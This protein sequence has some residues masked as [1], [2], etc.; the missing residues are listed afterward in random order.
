MQS[1]AFSTLIYVFNVLHVPEYV[2]NNAEKAIWIFLWD[3]KPDK[4]KRDMCRTGGIGVPNIKSILCAQQLKFLANVL[5]PGDENGKLLPRFFL[6]LSSNNKA[7]TIT[8]DKPII[9]SEHCIPHF[10]KSCLHMWKDLPQKKSPTV[11]MNTISNYLQP[12]TQNEDQ[13]LRRFE[14]VQP[15]LENSLFVKDTNKTWVDLNVCEQ[16]DVVNLIEG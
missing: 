14:D 5:R 4:V 6:N 15:N 3:G 10:Y 11:S 9:I 1:V 12:V 13:H 7:D 8:R 16:K 2:I